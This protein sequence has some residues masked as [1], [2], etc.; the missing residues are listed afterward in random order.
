MDVEFKLVSFKKTAAFM[1]KAVSLFK[2]PIRTKQSLEEHVSKVLTFW[3]VKTYKL[4]KYG[5][6]S[7]N[8][9][10]I[11]YLRNC[12][13]SV[14]LYKYSAKTNRCQFYSCPWCWTRTYSFSV[15]QKL[16][17]LRQAQPDVL[18]YVMYSA[19]RFEKRKTAKSHLI[20]REHLKQV[21]AVRN[22][23]T[24]RKQTLGGFSLVYFE[25][26]PDGFKFVSRLLVATTD[27]TFC[28][29]EGYTP[30]VLSKNE[31]KASFIFGFYP[32][33]FLSCKSG[34]KKLV[35]FLKN[36]SKKDKGFNSFGQFYGRK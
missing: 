34:T 23:L 18:F 29:P 30:Q 28:P 24:R 17:K 3:R 32:F 21:S 12:P 7:T 31:V 9:V 11:Q 36:K 15:W 6:F 10:R 27:K 8:P 5:M 2:R 14:G 35:Y 25:P 20:Y 1:C 13:P 26:T 19:K 16:K 4:A 33:V 22:K